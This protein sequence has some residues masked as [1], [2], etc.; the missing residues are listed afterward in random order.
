MVI[1]SS[2][3][4]QVSWESKQYPNGVFTRQLIDILAADGGTTPLSKIFLQLKDNVQAEVLRD[5]GRVQTPEF[6][7]AWNGNDLKLNIVTK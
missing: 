2:A 3:P 5:R 1:C 6:K 4:D 7:S